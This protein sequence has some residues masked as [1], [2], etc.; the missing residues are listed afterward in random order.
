M[1]PGIDFS[2]VS[3]AAP[4]YLWLLVVPAT[5]LPVALWRMSRRIGQLRLLARRRLVPVRERFALVGDFPF[6]LCA[7]AAASCLIL[8]L[9]RPY[10]T[11]ATVRRGGVDVVVLQDG[12]ASMYV[13]DVAGDRWQRSMRFLRVL[14]D[15]LGWTEDRLAL[16]VFARIATPQIRLTTDPN[17]FFFFLD[18]LENKS[19]FRIEEDTTWD[20]NLE[21]GIHWGL[22]LLDRDE[23]VNGKSKNAKLFVMISDGEAWSGAVASALE[24]ANRQGVPV[25]VVGVGTTSGGVL[26]TVLGEDG[27]PLPDAPVQSVSRLAR[28]SLSR[29]A[30]IGNGQ[31]FEL[32]RDTDT[33]IATTIIDAGRRL[34]PSL[35]I[36]ERRDELYWPLLSMAGLFVVV[37]VVFLREQAEPWIQ[38][39][40][41]AAALV[42]LLQFWR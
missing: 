12:S 24:D 25:F 23:E 3:F 2:D 31:Y 30:A 39:A 35:G 10:G 17:T 36:V 28:A 13:S 34:A 27:D 5:L 20:T 16:A 29:I 8:A 38:L 6:W 21:L 33:H 4:Y 40:A 9:A 37:G 7:I 14:G 42:T 15:T 22:R 26:P 11:V 18:H 19:P 32:D 1:T 41:A